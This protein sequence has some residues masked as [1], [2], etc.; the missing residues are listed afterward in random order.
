MSHSSEDVSQLREL[1]IPDK[2]ARFALE[3]TTLLVLEDVC[4]PLSLD[5]AVEPEGTSGGSG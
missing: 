2:T 5:L 3:V 4:S 1:G